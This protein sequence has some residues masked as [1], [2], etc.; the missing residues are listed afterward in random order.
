MGGEE[1]AGQGE[2]A[3]VGQ[4]SAQAHL[5]GHMGYYKSLKHV[6]PSEDFP[7]APSKNKSKVHTVT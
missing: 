5:L 7:T 3:E 4:R 2:V 6:L 1:A